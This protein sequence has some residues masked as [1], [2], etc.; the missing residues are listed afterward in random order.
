MKKWMVLGLACCL[1]LAAGCGEQKQETAVKTENQVV[2]PY[3]ENM[4]KLGFTESVVLPKQPERVISLANTPVLALETLG[5][6]Q[7]GIPDTK[8]LQWPDSLKQRAKLLQTG[9]RS[10]I[11]LETV[12]T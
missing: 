12:L 3:P 2:L 6:P 9:M 11:D 1:L 10:N 4:Q 8:I 7:V 5:V